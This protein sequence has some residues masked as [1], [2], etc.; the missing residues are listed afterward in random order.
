MRYIF[1]QAAIF[2]PIICLFI[3]IVL[4][5]FKFSEAEDQIL[6]E[7]VFQE[8]KAKEV[9]TKI[10]VA[11]EAV[12][13]VNSLRLLKE[14]SLPKTFVLEELAA[15]LPDGT[16]I[17]DLEFSGD[18]IKFSGFSNSAA[19][20]I[21]RLEATATLENVRFISPVVRSP[22]EAGDRFEMAAEILSR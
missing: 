8:S 3:L 20:L 7:I 18:Q 21:S 4:I 9:R 5:G 19:H 16:Y 6:Q 10:K 14:K 1:G 15:A 2:M 13:K 22:G 11:S 12:Q 17:T